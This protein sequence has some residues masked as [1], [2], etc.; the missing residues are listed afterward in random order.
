MGT[1]AGIIAGIMTPHFLIHCA[2]CGLPILLPADT[3]QRPFADPETQPND[4]LAVGVVCHHCKSAERYFLHQKHPQHNPKDQ[5]YVME[6]RSEDT[7]HVANLECEEETC[8]FRLPLFAYWNPASNQ[9]ERKDDM[10]TW[11]WEHLL[12]PEGHSI[13]KPD[14]RI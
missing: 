4:T 3:L 5:A 7:V 8:E 12:C 6:T 1:R 2:D 10:K 13:A 9:Q 14:W 11:R